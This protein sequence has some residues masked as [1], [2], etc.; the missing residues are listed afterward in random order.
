LRLPVDPGCFFEAHTYRDAAGSV[1]EEVR[2]YPHW[3]AFLRHVE[4]HGAGP[5]D[6]PN[7]KRALAELPTASPELR[8]M[9]F[10]ELERV[11][12][13]VARLKNHVPSATSRARL[14]AARAPRRTGRRARVRRLARDGPGRSS[15]DDPEPDRVAVRSWGG[16]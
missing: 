9:F 10:D 6:D 7:G 16:S 4:E 1:V 12:V 3:T 15:D 2:A 13:H 14:R 5:A 11:M 8:R